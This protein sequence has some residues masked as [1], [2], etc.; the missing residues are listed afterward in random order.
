M[1]NDLAIISHIIIRICPGQAGWAAFGLNAT[2]N[3]LG[4]TLGPIIGGFFYVTC[5]LKRP[6]LVA[7][8]LFTIALYELDII[9]ISFNS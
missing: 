4:M 7:G 5:F 6:F 1:V 9:S 2:E 8:L 3:R